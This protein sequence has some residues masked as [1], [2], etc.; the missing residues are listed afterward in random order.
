MS[1]SITFDEL[2]GTIHEGDK[3]GSVVFK[4]RNMVVAEQDLVACETVEAPNPLETMSIW[5]MRLVGGIRGEPAQ[6]ESL[7][8]NVMPV[9]S[10]N[11]SNAA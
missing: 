2:H 11:V 7:I 9:I 3:V 1:Q 4:Q 10:N 8:Y 6:A 5:W